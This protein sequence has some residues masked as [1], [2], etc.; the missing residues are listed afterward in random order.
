MPIFSYTDTLVPYGGSCTSRGAD[1]EHMWDSMEPPV[2]QYSYHP[3]PRR[4]QDGQN[5]LPWVPTQ[6]SVIWLYGLYQYMGSSGR[7]KA[8]LAYI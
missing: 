5:D 3:D 7:V 4:S 1:M 8:L 6:D 2:H